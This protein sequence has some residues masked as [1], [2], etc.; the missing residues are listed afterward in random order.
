MTIVC[1]DV[2]LTRSHDWRTFIEFHLAMTA[3]QVAHD[4]QPIKVWICR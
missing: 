1:L 3:A 4:D 2:E